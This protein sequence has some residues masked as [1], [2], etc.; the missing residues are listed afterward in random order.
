M[1][2][3]RS[4]APKVQGFE[5][6]ILRK[7]DIVDLSTHSKL[8]DLHDP[9]VS[10]VKCEFVFRAGKIYD[11][12]P[13][14]SLLTSKL[15]PFNRLSSGQK[16]QEFVDR[17]GGYLDISTNDDYFTVTLYCISKYLSSLLPPFLEIFQITNF[18]QDDFETIQQVT[19]EELAI[20]LTKGKYIANQKLK[21]QLFDGTQYAR[22]IVPDN[23][24][25]SS[26]EKL[27]SFH[28]SNLITPIL[29]NV[30]GNYESGTIQKLIEVFK[31]TPAIPLQNDSL[32]IPVIDSEEGKSEQTS[33]RFG[34]KLPISKVQSLGAK[35]YNMMLGGYFGSRLMTTLREKHGLTYG[36]QA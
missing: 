17:F 33:I 10:A 18:E 6:Y 15:L 5:D 3:D 23:I 29:I 2:V 20:N 24:D 28:A 7:P 36:I 1:S 32:P 11:R 19:Q 14:D 21:E 27:Q 31:S 8:L 13:A 12:F 16:L 35:V 25:K 4:V 30:S 22:P 34:S 26:L 9:N